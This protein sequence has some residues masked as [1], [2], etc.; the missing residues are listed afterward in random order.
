MTSQKYI[1]FRIFNLDY[2]YI[3][4]KEH[5]E[6]TLNVQNQLNLLQFGLNMGT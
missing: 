1:Y 6:I 4:P 2:I 5:N 3:Y